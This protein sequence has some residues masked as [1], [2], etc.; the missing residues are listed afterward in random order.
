MNTFRKPKKTSPL[1][2][3]VGLSIKEGAF[4]QVYNSVLAPGSIFI[5]K[6]AIFLNALPFHFGLLF[7]IGQLSQVF[8]P[9]GV[10]LT[11]KLTSR[12][13]SV[14]VLFI[15]A[16]I[17]SFAIGFI[18]FIFLPKFR[19]GPFLVIFFICTSL[20]AIG[21][22]AWIAWISDIVPLRIRGR[23]FSWRSQA[24]M[25][26]GLI[27]GYLLGGFLRLIHHNSIQ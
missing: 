22:N 18:P 25:F 12:K 17:L 14:T 5:T 19:I 13:K 21:M 2:K 20:H 8:Q 26:A 10:A 15:V 24:M 9:V 3:T 16:R 23:F 27:S 4:S 1:R 7:S 6:F 11:R